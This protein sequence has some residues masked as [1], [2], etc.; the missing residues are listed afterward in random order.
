MEAQPESVSPWTGYGPSLNG[1][2]A[3]VLCTLK[4]TPCLSP[5]TAEKL[6]LRGAQGLLEEKSA[7]GGGMRGD[8]RGWAGRLGAVFR[9]PPQPQP[10]QLHL[11]LFD[12]NFCLRS[13]LC[14]F[15]FF[16]FK[17]RKR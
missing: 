15:F 5:A 9:S 2:S 1:K 17:D 11:Y 6:L 12:R 3:A 10:Q 16:F 14:C 7:G 13:E 8:A 4:P